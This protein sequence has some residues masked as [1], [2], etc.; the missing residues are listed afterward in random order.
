MSVGVLGLAGCLEDSNTENPDDESSD[1]AEQSS[2]N[3]GQSSD[4]S[5]QSSDN[6][7]Q[8]SDNSEQSTSTP[9]VT[10]STEVDTTITVGSQESQTY[11][12]DIQN[13]ADVR[14]TAQTDEGKDPV[15][16]VTSP[17]GSNVIDEVSDSIVRESF[18]TPES[19]SYIFRFEN[20]ARLGESGTW[21]ISIDIC[22]S[23]SASSTTPSPT[24][25]TT[26]S[27]EVDTTITVGS[28]E[29]QTYNFDIQN[30]ADV[31][32]TAQTDEG[33]D[34][35]VTVTSPSGSNV[36][37]EVSDSIVRESFTTPES[38][39]YIFRFENGARLGESGTWSISIE[40]CTTG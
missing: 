22:S 34:P 7:E 33:K 31:R 3:S 2:D 10:C 11:N 24:P 13:G 30:G 5:G 18:T 26:C 8:S 27:K 37:D 39:S 12:F 35:V 16:T 14:V 23:E 1:N 28:Q 36:I 29:S 15:V 19:G 6:S 4:N 40:I 38:G 9:E 17:S 20:G 21:S 25:E 32:V